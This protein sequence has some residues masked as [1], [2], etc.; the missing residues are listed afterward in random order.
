MLYF[1]LGYVCPHTYNPADFFITTVATAMI[2]E[3]E[4]SK[5]SSQRI[6]DAFLSSDACKELDV[7]LQLEVHVAESDV[8]LFII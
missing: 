3:N 7:I 2:H 8:R 6:C 4:D 1:R 5:R